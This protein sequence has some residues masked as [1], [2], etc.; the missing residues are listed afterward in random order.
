MGTRVL[1]GLSGVL[2]KLLAMVFLVGHGDIGESFGNLGEAY[3]SG[4]SV[5][6]ATV[7]GV[8]SGVLGKLVAIVFRE[9]CTPA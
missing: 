4:V 3:D 7:P 8:L 9:S 6:G 2:G 5:F 1:N